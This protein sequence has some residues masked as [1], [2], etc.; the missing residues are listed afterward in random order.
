MHVTSRHYAGNADLVDALV[1][2]KDD[3]QRIISEIDG[4]K[5]YYLVRTGDDD[6]LSISVFDDAAGGDRS[7]EV[8]RDW[9]A[10]N[11]PDMH[12]SPPAVLAGDAELAF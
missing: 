11:L 8:A 1:E 6:A 2:R 4:F 7:V 12:V 5:A 3:V 10:E 9:I